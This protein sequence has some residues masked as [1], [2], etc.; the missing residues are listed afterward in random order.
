MRSSLLGVLGFAVALG[1]CS[2]GGGGSIGTPTG[3]AGDGTTTPGG[4]TPTDGT[5]TV[6]DG[7]TVPKS[8]TE[9]L[10]ADVSI[11]SVDVYQAVKVTI[12]KDGSS[13]TPKLPLVAARDAL[14]RVAVKPGEGFESRTLKGIL[15]VVDQDGKAL[16]AITD[17]KT[18]KAAS[19]DASLASTFN[20]R[21]PGDALPLGAKLAVAITDDQAKPVAEG[22]ESTARFPQD[23][24]EGEIGLQSAGPSV[25]IVIVPIKY[26][27]DGSGRMP[28][29]SQSQLDLNRDAMWSQYPVPAVDI[30]VRAPWT[31]SKA[32]KGNG[33]GWSE[34]LQALVDLREQDGVDDDVYYWG[35]FSA[36]SSQQQFCG[37]GCVMGL[38]TLVSDPRNAY[39]RASIGVGFS[40]PQSAET[41][42][43]E[44]GHAHG[45]NHAPC[46]DFGQ[47]DGVDPKFPYSTG[48]IGV[49]GYDMVSDKLKNPSNT[50]DFMGYCD[51][52][53]VSDYT[54][55]ALFD[56]IATV[57]KGKPP[58][59]VSNGSGAGGA[60][61][62]QASSAYQFV[63][64][65]LEGPMSFGKEVSIRK[66]PVG[67]PREVQL[68]D[69]KGA[70]VSVVRGDY[71][72]YDHLDGGSLLFPTPKVGYK[73]IKVAGFARTLAR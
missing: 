9:K 57:N 38:S 34:L 31:W 67:E 60:G 18:I 54:Y 43:H 68:L 33:T 50:A 40:G 44:I 52:T 41:L 14:I 73:S 10:A 11:S 19:T 39:F 49:W 42:V 13:V 70:V 4:E 17:E 66:A 29:T 32:V 16:K 8:V 23:G 36:A 53:W 20:F 56:R 28:D 61:S 51:G 26:A 45:R 7:K 6:D 24:T 72:A 63:T 69:E 3:G 12:A 21:V 46:S 25:K 35:A 5:T 22:T 65:G 1:A 64:M 15:R 58:T 62:F 59:T 2:G 47:I 30:S 55:K 48:S 37:S 27:A 71:F